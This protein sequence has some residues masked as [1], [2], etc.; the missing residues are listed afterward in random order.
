[1]E[2]LA[3]DDRVSKVEILNPEHDDGLNPRVAL[4]DA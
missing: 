2:V 4:V 1:M 3:S